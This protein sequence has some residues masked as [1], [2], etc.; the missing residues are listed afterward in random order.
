[1]GAGVHKHPYYLEPGHGGW[2]GNAPTSLEKDPNAA[3]VVEYDNLL[4]VS[5]ARLCI[6]QPLLDVTGC[7]KGFEKV[8]LRHLLSKRKIIM[9]TLDSLIRKAG[10]GSNL[11]S[12]LTPIEKEI[13]EAFFEK[14]SMDE[15]QGDLVELQNE[16]IFIR[17]RLMTLGL[18][19]DV[20]DVSKDLD[21]RPAAS[22]F[23]GAVASKTADNGKEHESSGL[24]VLEKKLK[25]GAALVEMKHSKL[26]FLRGLLR[27]RLVLRS[28]STNK[29]E[30]VLSL[31]EATEVS[32]DV[33]K[34]PVAVASFGAGGADGDAFGGGGGSGKVGSDTSG[35]FAIY[36][37]ATNPGINMLN[38]AKSKMW[39]A[40]LFMAHANDSNLVRVDTK[41]ASDTLEE[42]VDCKELEVVEGLL[43][44]GVN[45]TIESLEKAV[46]G[47]DIVSFVVV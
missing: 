37:S 23:A 9:A 40:V 15:I 8:A 42:A 36:L 28:E 38:A 41:H 44:L 5:T 2:E 1:L 25:E 11:P 45:A 32:A 12:L 18:Q 30:E 29:D 6:L 26:S 39:Q 34:E 17:K 46:N 27:D 10:A 43:R 14:I 21:L 13:T 31:L 3:K 16:L 4:K 47:G 19:Y 24:L 7:C 33:A 20:L 22:S 35:E